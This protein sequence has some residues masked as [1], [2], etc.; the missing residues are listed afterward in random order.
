VTNTGFVSFISD[1]PFEKF[2]GTSKSLT[3]RIDAQTDTV[4]FYLDLNTLRTG[5][6]LRDEH[7]R[8][9]Y[10]ETSKYPFA[11]F[12]GV[13][14]KKPDY[15]R[16]TRQPVQVKGQFKIHGVAR[17]MVIDGFLTPTANGIDIEAAWQVKLSDHNIPIPSIIIRKLSEIQDVSIKASLT[18]ATKK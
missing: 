1:A 8:E 7:M 17:E 2:T 3:G 12:Y 14:V 9:N 11:E 18:P 15:T 5:I 10:L 13:L 6:K 16:R 4:D